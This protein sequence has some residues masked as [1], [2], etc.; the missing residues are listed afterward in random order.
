MRTRLLAHHCLKLSQARNFRDMST[1]HGEKVLC[2]CE[3]RDIVLDILW[4]E[5]LCC[6]FYLSRRW[7]HFPCFPEPRPGVLLLRAM[8][9]WWQELPADSCP[10]RRLGR[11]WLGAVVEVSFPG[12]LG[13]QEPYEDGDEIEAAEDKTARTG[14]WDQ[15]KLTLDALRNLWVIKIS[16]CNWLEFSRGVELP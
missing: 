4:Y 12:T 10:L 2:V 16:I 3:P 13:C 7:R 11:E 5:H 1:F 9:E 6:G 14:L 15:V 8:G